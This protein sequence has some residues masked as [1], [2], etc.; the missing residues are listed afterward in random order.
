MDQGW[1]DQE[2]AWEKSWDPA[3]LPAHLFSEDFGCSLADWD[4]VVSWED[5]LERCLWRP[6]PPQKCNVYVVRKF[7]GF[8]ARKIQAKI[9]I[10]PPANHVTLVSAEKSHLMHAIFPPLSSRRA[11]LGPR[12]LCYPR[13]K[14]PHSL[15]WIYCLVCEWFHRNNEK[16]MLMNPEDLT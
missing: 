11:G 16:E 6:S 12:T 4:G 7:V 2:F 1:R 8:G 3:S 9:P 14:S 10:L 5:W 13:D 15:C